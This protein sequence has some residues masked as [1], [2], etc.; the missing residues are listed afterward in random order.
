VSGPYQVQITARAARDLQRLPEKIA[1]ACVKFIF[2]PLIVNPRQVGKP[3]EM[4]WPALCSS[5]RL[6]SRLR[7]RR[8]HAAGRDRAH[9]PAQRRLPIATPASADLGTAQWE[10]GYSTYAFLAKDR[11]ALLAHRG[12]ATRLHIWDR[13]GPEVLSG[14]T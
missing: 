9:R 13:R 2:G 12:G 3:A 7:L 6:P 1:A 14:P 11:I 4:S 8:G 10:F 5:W